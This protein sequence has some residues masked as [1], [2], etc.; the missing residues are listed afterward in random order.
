[1]PHVCDQF[2]TLPP[3]PKPPLMPPGRS[4]SGSAEV[5]LTLSGGCGAVTS[6]VIGSLLI[7]GVEGGESGIAVGWLLPAL[8]SP[9]ACAGSLPG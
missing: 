4:W 1:M 8:P 6:S 3:D 2:L 5:L 9:V 7:G